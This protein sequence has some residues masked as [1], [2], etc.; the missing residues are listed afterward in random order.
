MKLW[1]HRRIEW[2]FRNRQTGQITIGQVPNVP[3]V[4]FIVAWVLDR[5]FDPGGSIGTALAVLGFAALTIWA[6]DEIVRGVNPWRRLL[7]A[8]VL[9]ALVAQLL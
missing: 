1:E 5:V 3:L 7:G 8:G 6:V 4:V 2:L 9:G